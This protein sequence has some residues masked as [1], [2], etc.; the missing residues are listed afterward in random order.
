MGVSPELQMAMGSLAFL[1][2]TKQLSKVALGYRDDR[3]F[4]G[5]IK[6][7][8]ASNGTSLITNYVVFRGTKVSENENRGTPQDQARTK[9]N[10]SSVQDETTSKLGLLILGALVNPPG[11]D[12]KAHVG[13]FV[14]LVN[15]TSTRCDLTGLTIE[16]NNGVKQPLMG[17]VGAFETV[18]IILD[19][20]SLRNRKGKIVLRDGQET[21]LDEV[22]YSGESAQREEYLMTGAGLSRP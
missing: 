1:M 15:N 11:D 14:D 13:E 22:E 17:E 2:D 7:F 21:M 3:V 12:K 20:A 19:E 8:P 5:D 10:P 4:W 9:Q 16:G 18:R 6:R